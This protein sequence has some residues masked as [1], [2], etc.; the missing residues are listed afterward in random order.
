[1]LGEFGRGILIDVHGQKKQPNNFLRG[2]KNGKTVRDLI[3]LYGEAAVIVC[4]NS[5]IQKF[6][7]FFDNL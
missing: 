1:M 6:L 3:D 4:K 2:T 5:A 7:I